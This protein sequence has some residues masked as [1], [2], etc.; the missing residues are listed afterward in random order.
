M[1]AS[2]R[3]LRLVFGIGCCCANALAL[4]LSLALIDVDDDVVATTVDV[5]FCC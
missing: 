4:A 1:V 2:P 3:L 5:V